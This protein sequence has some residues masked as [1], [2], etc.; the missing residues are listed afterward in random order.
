VSLAL[1]DTSFIGSSEDYA[2]QGFVRPL[3]ERLKR[4]VPDLQL[5]RIGAPGIT[6]SHLA[7][8]LAARTAGA[9]PA[10]A[11]LAFGLSDV[12]QDTAGARFAGAVDILVAMSARAA[13]LCVVHL[14]PDLALAPRYRNSRR[15]SAIRERIGALNRVLRDAAQRH[16]AAVA[17]LELWSFAAFNDESLFAGDGCYPSTE[18]HAVWAQLTW[19][20]YERCLLR[21]SGRL[22][23]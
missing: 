20:V 21:D 3:H 19:P 10:L 22:G 6:A 1:G 18:G 9:R 12:F 4:L 14:L 16:G 17:D 13:Q 23:A 15:T 11:T 8:R 7:A 5:E 2:S